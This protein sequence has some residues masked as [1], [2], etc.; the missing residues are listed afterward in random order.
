MFA[1]DECGLESDAD[2]QPGRREGEQWLVQL[3]SKTECL[4]IR[5]GSELSINHWRSFVPTCLIIIRGENAA[6][7]EADGME[8]VSNDK[9]P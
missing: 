8:I 9:L 1:G 7:C 2:D 5:L 4:S 3:G 6:D